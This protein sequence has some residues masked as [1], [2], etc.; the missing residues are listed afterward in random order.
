[1]DFTFRMPA[2]VAE[3]MDTVWI[4]SGTIEKPGAARHELFGARRSTQGSFT[5]SAADRADLADGRL[6]VRFYLHDAA[7]SAG[8]VPL[9]F[10]K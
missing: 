1:M 6:I 10:N 7:G 9:S 5:V 2:A 4:H 3:R 8:D